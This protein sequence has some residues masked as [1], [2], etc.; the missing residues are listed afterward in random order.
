MTKLRT[1]KALFIVRICLWVVALISTVYWI[2]YSVKLHTDGIYDPYEY[3][4]LFRPVFY[5]CLAVSVLAICI[6]FALYAVSR[7]MKER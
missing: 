1:V 4:L 3:A 2:W 7:K 5:P 6:S